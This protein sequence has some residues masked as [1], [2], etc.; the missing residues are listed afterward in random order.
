VAAAAATVFEQLLVQLNA[1]RSVLVTSTV[2]GRLT[3]AFGA[4][5]A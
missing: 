5:K 1:L 3:L 4:R 2:K